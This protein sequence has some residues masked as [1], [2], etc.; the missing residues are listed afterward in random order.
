MR[1]VAT[2]RFLRQ[3]FS[4]RTWIADANDGVIATAG[5]LEGFAGAGAGDRTLMIAALVMIAAGT[6]ALGG[7]KWAE[8]AGELD[9]ERRVI[10]DERAL[11]AQDPD[12]EVNELAAF[13]EN[14]GLTPDVA[15]RVAEQLSARDALAAQLEFEY[16]IDEPTPSWAPLLAGV[17]AAGAFA[18]G[19]L[20]P[21]LITV[22]VSAQIE[23]WVIVGAVVISLLVTSW[24]GAR[25]GRTSLPR[26]ITRTV[27]IGLATLAVSYLLGS[28]LI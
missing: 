6:F 24:L 15:R 13:W 9:A 14:K 12:S 22:F 5:L 26:M 19:S 18:F 11:L 1:V 10:A 2:A 17:R 20:I 4:P 28:L 23:A 25:A 7:A 27:A 3:H 21:L 16:G 8:A